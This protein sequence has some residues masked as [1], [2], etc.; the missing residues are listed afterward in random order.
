L[1]ARLFPGMLLDACAGAAAL[2]I[3]RTSRFPKRSRSRTRRYFG[4]RSSP[5]IQPDA[6]PDLSG[7]PR[8]QLSH[9]NVR[10]LTPEGSTRVML[11]PHFGQVGRSAC[12]MA[13]ICRQI[14]WP[15][16][17]KWNSAERIIFL[18]MELPLH[19]LLHLSRKK[20]PQL[21]GKLRPPL[22]ASCVWAISTRSHNQ[23]S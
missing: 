3:G 13:C 10:P 7:S 16:H 18:R 4:G 22:G 23:L 15:V 8:S 19:G 12:P 1:R 11:A 2:P 20:R 14:R 5:L 17:S 6:L 21:G 9:C